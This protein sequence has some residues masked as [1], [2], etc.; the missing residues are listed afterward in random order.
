MIKISKPPAPAVLQGRG[1][2]KRAKHCADYDRSPA[3]Y[4]AGAKTFTFD[5]ALYGHASVKQALIAAQHGKCCF[6]ERKIGAEGDVEHFRPKASFCQGERSPLERP[7]YY[8]LAYEWDNLLLACPICNQRFKRNY[9]PLR[10][11]RSGQETI[12]ATWRRK[13]RS[14]STP[15]KWTPPALSA[16]ARKF[17]MRL[18]AINAQKRPSKRWGWTGKT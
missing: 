11:P 5:D 13:N 4:E 18:T 12:T 8:W 17:P 1:Q 3:D 15:P 2:A 6:C 10:S 7:G 14:L 16:S 9:F